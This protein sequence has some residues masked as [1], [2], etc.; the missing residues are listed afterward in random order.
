MKTFDIY[1][2]VND[3]EY[4]KI[5]CPHQEED[6]FRYDEVTIS[7]CDSNGHQY[8]LYTDD[9][10][11]EALRCFQVLLERVINNRSALDTSIESGITS[12]DIG[13]LWNEDLQA[14]DYLV[15][16]INSDG[17]K[18]WIGLNHL[19]WSSLRNL[20]TWLYN[21]QN[22]IFI[23]ITP[24]YQWHFNNPKK[25]HIFVTYDEFMK[26]Y[27]PCVIREISKEIAQEWLAKVN[28]LLKIVEANDQKYL[29]G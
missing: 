27:R 17:V 13:Y 3:K 24:V 26:N 21:S 2:K 4:I 16:A 14:K 11:I 20:T 28:Q 15:T 9:F 6:L 19:L 23:E 5:E 25:D 12:R 8:T 7:F 22:K 29:I 1:F 18:Y 10:I